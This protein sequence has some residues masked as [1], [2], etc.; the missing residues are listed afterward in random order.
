VTAVLLYL[1][2]AL[3]TAVLLA[4]GVVLARALGVRSLGAGLGWA[5][6]LLFGAM[7]VTFAVSAS[8]TL[9]LVLVLAA[10]AAALP[11][12]LRRRVEAER[13]P[14]FAAAAVL[15]VTL[16]ILL[17]HVAGEIGGDGL[18][19]LARARKLLDFGDLSL[20]SMNEFP[21]GGLHPGY[22]FP[23]WHGLLA[24]VARL[25]GV[26]PADVVLH[27]PSLL[28]PLAVLLWFEAGWVLF[29]RAVPA[30]AA[31][32]AAVCLVAMAPAH[33]GA[34]T[35]LALPATAS[36]QLLVP[37]VLALAFALVR[38][39]AWP[40]AASVAAGAL[41]LAVVHPTY[42][43]FLTIPF[44][45]FV[46]VRL[47]WNRSDGRA[48]ALALGALTVPAA[49]YVAW[50]LPVVN[51]TASVSPGTAARARA[52]A[53]YDGQLDVRSLDSFSVVP[54]LFG[55]SGAIAVAALL[56]V[57][58]AGLAARRRWAAFVVGGALAVFVLTLVPFL[59]VPFSDLVSV[60][61]ARRLAGF[62][63]FPFAF[64]GG[65]GVLASL[66]GPL[67]A[68]LALVGG[69]VLQLAFPG[70]FDYRLT[71]G[72][73]A[74]VTWIAVAGALV[75]LAAG[76]RHRA[77]RERSAGLASMLALLPVVVHGLVHWSP[78]EARSASPLSAGLVETLRERIP[79]AA[80]V[81]ADPE[82]SYRVAAFAPVRICVAPPG[83]VAD[84]VENHPRE[85]VVELRRFLATGDL[86]IPRR[87]GAGWLVIDRRRFDLAPELPVL[88]RDERWV[89]YR[90]PGGGEP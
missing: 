16:G 75:A 48:G 29:R 84:T 25:A 6:A 32:G 28:A 17:W 13:I 64:A 79:E 63:P 72:G 62:L 26:D 4:P 87:C 80:T 9:T 23:L 37:A 54:E 85:R 3:A 10:G 69:I 51:D 2:L 12:A 33:G 44:A 46:L 15:G 40:L 88:Y 76:F 22:A 77:S 41:A 50:L 61:Q 19:H 1:R 65:M 86:A 8:L 78:S 45:A 59:F 34:Y 31:A 49:A 42:A 27:L 70:D 83:H 60:S 89:L 71:D 35:A 90:L 43:I 56:L 68:P 14:G 57:P 39:P 11:F 21:D 38:R 58:F 81:Y 53:Q 73:P 67:T 82:T 30:A 52:I 18:F 20:D 47:A 55:R 7:A 24:L 66:L 74:V 36:R 5:L